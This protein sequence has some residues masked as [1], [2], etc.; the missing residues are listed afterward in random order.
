MQKFLKKILCLAL[1]LAFSLVI[2]TGC[3]TSTKQKPDPTVTDNP[4]KTDKPV[5]LKTITY[6]GSADISSMDPR[7]GVSTITAS[8]LADVYSTLVKTDPDGK[9]VCDLAVSYDRI[10]DV[11]WR[12]KLRDD[13]FFTNGDRL[14]SAD[15]KYTF[16]TLRSNEGNYALAGDFSF[17]R[18]EPINDF[19]LDLITDFP[20]NSLLLRLNYVKIIPSKYVQKVGDDVFAAAPIGSGPFKF[21]SW[22]KDEEVVLEKNPDYY[23]EVPNFD[24]LIYRTIPETSD[25][26][27]ALQAGE[28]DIIQ[29]IPTTQVDFL[30]GLSDIKVCK[31]PSTALYWLQFNLVGPETPLNDRRVRQAINYA[32]NR[33]LIID[34][35]LDGNAVKSVSISTPS[36]KGYDPNVKGYEYDLEK[37]KQLMASAGYED[38][39]DIEL[40]VVPGGSGTDVVQSIAAQLADINITVEIRQIDNSTKIEQQ[41]AGTIAPLFLQGLGGPYCDI[42]LIA[43]IGFTKGARYCTW[44]NQ[45]FIDLAARARSTVDDNECAELYSRMQQFMIDEAPC[46]WLYQSVTLYAYNSKRIQGWDTRMDDTV[47]FDGTTVVE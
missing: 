9:I 1:C 30:S 46:L 29:S 25:R 34:G 4:V 26:V 41:K 3:R 36:Y 32:V 15:V 33:D 45:E 20:F 47:S 31:Q 8:I 18:A 12:F 17:I 19:E 44:D 28:V 40:V 24:R 37:A 16:D 35:V 7:R 6:A 39:F 23:G 14:T 10:N 11:T 27:A 38:G 2:F 22:S 5:K 42:D 21:V 13:V 43:T